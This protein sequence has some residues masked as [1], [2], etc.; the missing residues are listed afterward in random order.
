M[1]HEI[2][3]I[4]TYTEKHIRLKV[5]NHQNFLIISFIVHLYWAEDEFGL[6]ITKL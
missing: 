1:K 6:F 4:G 2:L 3:D 5:Q